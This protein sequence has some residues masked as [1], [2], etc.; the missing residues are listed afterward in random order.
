MH[1]NTVF[2]IKTS[3]NGENEQI[4]LKNPVVMLQNLL[5][6]VLFLQ[7]NPLKSM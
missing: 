4:Q 6:L 5:K 3:K 7:Y 2:T 1:L